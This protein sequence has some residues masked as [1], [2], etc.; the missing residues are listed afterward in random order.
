MG[1][2]PFCLGKEVVP[3]TLLGL[4][5]RTQRKLKTNAESERKPDFSR[6]LVLIK[7]R[8]A[9]LWT[10]GLNS[11][12]SNRLLR[13]TLFVPRTMMSKTERNQ[14]F[15]RVLAT[16][17]N[18]NAV[19]NFCKSRIAAK[20]PR[21]EFMN[22]L[23]AIPKMQGVQHRRRNSFASLLGVRASLNE[24]A[25]ALTRQLPRLRS[26]RLPSW[27]AFPYLSDLF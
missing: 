16:V 21:L 1:S 20:H 17:G 24:A 27:S 25:R 4:A 8:A 19:V 11:G 26:M 13:L 3:S 14:I 12:L 5:G 22:A 15:E 6:L 10:L 23:F 2:P 18:W 7:L 9:E